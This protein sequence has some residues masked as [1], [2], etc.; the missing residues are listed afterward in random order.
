[1]AKSYHDMNKQYPFVLTTYDSQENERLAQMLA[2][3]SDVIITGSAP[4]IYTKMRIEQGKADL[5]IFRAHLQAGHMAGAFAARFLQHDEIPSQISK[6]SA[7]YAL[8]E[9]IYAF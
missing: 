9:R 1:M 3:R 7:L 4:E 5:P 2:M 8:C 6:G